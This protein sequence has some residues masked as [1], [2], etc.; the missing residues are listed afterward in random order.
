MAAKAATGGMFRLLPGGHSIYTLSLQFYRNLCY[1]VVV[2]TA[3]EDLVELLNRTERS[4]RSM[5]TEA[6]ESR[7]YDDV[8]VLAG[9]AEQI[10]RILT[11]FDESFVV[12]QDDGDIDSDVGPQT[13]SNTSFPRF[14][15][16]GQILV[17][18]ARSR[19]GAETY[20]H[21]APKDVLDAIVRAIP[22][23]VNKPNKPFTA[24]QV[25][26]SVSR[27]GSRIPAYQVYLC[28][29]WMKRSGVLRQHGRKGYTVTNAVNL[30]VNVNK[31]WEQ[32]PSYEEVQ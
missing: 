1:T 19:V 14:A 11:A 13:A 12:R 15:R 3:K 9:A 17:K 8:Q 28:I 21:R 16:Q 4:V 25:S 27:T 20:E 5:L 7:R 18:T 32:L 29:G 26:A 30:P 10:H 22:V 24:E 23:L 31:L 2:T 6:V